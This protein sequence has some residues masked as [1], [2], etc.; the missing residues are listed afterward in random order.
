MLISGFEM[1]K[2]TIAKSNFFNKFN[3]IVNFFNNAVV[4]I[5]FKRQ[6]NMIRKFII[7]IFI[8]KRNNIV[9]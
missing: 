6:N 1:V 5:I 3:K 9:K 7:Y 2:T 4:Q 8:F